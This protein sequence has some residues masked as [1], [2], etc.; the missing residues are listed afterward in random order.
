[1]HPGWQIALLP[2]MILELAMLALGCGIIISALTTKYRDLAMLVSFGVQLWMYA[3]PVAYAAEMFSG[4]KLEIIYWCNPICPIIETI[5]YGFL[6]EAAAQFRPEMWGLS[7]IITACILALGVILFS[8]VEKTF[9][10]T[11]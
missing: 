6:G 3:S 1:M 8:K 9:M 2:L 5:K 7:W 4:S 11:V 10:D